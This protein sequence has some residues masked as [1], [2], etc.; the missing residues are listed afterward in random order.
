MLDDVSLSNI[1][2]PALSKVINPK[3]LAIMCLHRAVL[4]VTQANDYL[5]NHLLLLINIVYLY[6]DKS[7]SVHG[8]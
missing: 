2:V 6:G 8:C 7:S 3:Q 1:S 4:R 5:V